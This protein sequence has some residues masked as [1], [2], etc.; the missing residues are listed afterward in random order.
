MTSIDIKEYLFHAIKPYE[1][2]YNEAV[3]DEIKILINIITSGAIFSRRNLKSILPEEE[4]DKL[5]KGHQMN[6]NKLDW[7]S[8]APRNDTTINFPTSYMINFATQGMAAFYEHVIKFPSIILNPTLLH[9]L[10][11]ADC[12]DDEISCQNGEIQVK[13]KISSDYF[14]GIA[15]PNIYDS[16]ELIKNSISESSEYYR[17]RQELKELEI[18]DFLN[19]YYK[20]AILFEKALN[21][22]NSKLPIFHIESGN[23]ILPYNQELEE[24]AKVKKIFLK[25]RL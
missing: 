6:W 2:H 24:L 19:R 10:I 25:N 3:K 18:E 17:L 7:I 5:C 12:W 21:S 1:F 14:V 4:F 8:I 9:D 22:I 23:P 13:D 16:S 15:L 11:I 20:N